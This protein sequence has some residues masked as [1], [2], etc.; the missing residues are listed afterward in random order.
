MKILRVRTGFT[1]NSSSAAE[2]IVVEPETGPGSDTEATAPSTNATSD[3][4][5]AA[6]TAAVRPVVKRVEPSPE[7][8][9]NNSLLLALLV[10][11]LALLFAIERVVRRL[12]RRRGESV[13]E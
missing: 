8:A 9:W 10:A 3:T 5:V 1:T 7:T 2:W 11:A 13:D 4:A 12:L 6:D